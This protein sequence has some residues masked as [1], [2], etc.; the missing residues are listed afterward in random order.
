M[1]TKPAR[2]ADLAKGPAI[3]AQADG[4]KRDSQPTTWYMTPTKDRLSLAP[5]MPVRS[6]YLGS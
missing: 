3:N 2:N 5:K 1:F 4:P 6:A